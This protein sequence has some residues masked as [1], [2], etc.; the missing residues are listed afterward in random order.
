MPASPGAQA[1]RGTH[2]GVLLVVAH[3]EGVD[4]F[5]LVEAHLHQGNDSLQERPQAQPRHLG[6]GC[7]NGSIPGLEDPICSGAMKPVCHPQL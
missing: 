4:H 7:L 6:R 2:G 5:L 3:S 1:A